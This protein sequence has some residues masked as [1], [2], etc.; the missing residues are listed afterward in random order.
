M[1][2]AKLIYS[3]ICD[4]VRLEVG[5]KVSLMGVFQNVFLPTFPSVV[6]KFAVVNHWEGN[7]E[8]QTQVKILNPVREET[9]SSVP[10]S[11]TISGQ[12][13]ADNITFFTNVRFD[14]PG[15]Y[16][17]EVFLSGNLVEESP[18]YVRQVPSA[19]SGPVN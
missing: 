2:T 17:L 4:D 1:G 7:G 14:R 11:F 18:L 3:L 9:V 15:T 19:P 13:H 10:A 12:G 16:T 8:F 5:N 6:V